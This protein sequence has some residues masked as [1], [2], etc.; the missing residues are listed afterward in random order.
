[1][2]KPESCLLFA[3]TETGARPLP[4]PPHARDANEVFDGLSL[5]IYEGLRTFDH[6]RL[7]GLE[8]HLDRAQRSMDL[9]AWREELE[10]D[11]LR[12]AL[13][14][15]LTASPWP[16]ARVRFDVLAEPARELETESRMLIALSPLHPLPEDYLR[17]GTCSRLVDDLHRERPRIKEARFVIDRRVHPGGTREDYEPIMVDRRGRLLEGTSSNIFAVRDGVLRTA[18]EG[19][20]EGITRGVFIELAR[21]EGLSI[22]EEAVLTSELAALSEAFLTSSVR[23][24]VP[25]V[26]LGKVVVG[27]GRPGPIGMQLAR[28]YAARVEREARPA[29]PIEIVAR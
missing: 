14:E 15:A 20:L 5:G 29:W 2:A 4:A 23:S 6:V 27:S 9:L 7:F 21:A 25:I 1:M 19:V 13:H 26:Q 11:V 8:E 16:E 22:R 28:A 17:L 3:A 18:G 24:L 10:R 12:R